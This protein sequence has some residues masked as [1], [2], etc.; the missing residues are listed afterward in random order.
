MRDL[1][2]IECRNSEFSDLWFDQPPFLIDF[3]ILILV[4]YLIFILRD[5]ETPQF[6][7]H[8]PTIVERFA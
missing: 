2:V 8:L 4:S 3:M 1:K 7:Q 5:V 6:G